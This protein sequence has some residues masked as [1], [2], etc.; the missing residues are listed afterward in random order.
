MKDKGKDLEKFARKMSKEISGRVEERALM[1]RY[2]SFRI[3]G[4][5]E[6]MVFPKN[7]E[8]LALVVE[9]CENQG[10][11][12]K[13]LGRGSN[14]LVSDQG[15]DEVLI[16]LQEGFKG[17][18]SGGKGLVKAEAGVRLA[19]LVKLC[20][21]EGLSG[22]E[23]CAGIP[24]TVGGGLKMN[25][26]AEGSEIK[27]VVTRVE[28]HRYPEGVYSR[29]QKELRFEY[30]SL[31]LR[32]REII[33]GAE[34]ELRESDPREIR[35]RILEYLRSRRQ[36]QPIQWPSAGSVF[37]NPPGKYA[38]KI[39]EELG[40]KGH[41]SGDA[42]ISELHANFIIN[43]GRAKATQV[44]ELIELIREKALREKGIRLETE[45]EVIGRE[46]G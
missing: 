17:V 16:N 38:G 35:A 13:I 44:L 29:R 19:H 3:G 9:M 25:A 41:R 1:K 8:D 12:W 39:I 36:T 42:Q 21:D 11:A 14:L 43:R 26:G 37:K 30:R 2:T 23:F 20:Q 34:F 5:C 15:V 10:L 7:R 28:F 45:I 4:I 22:L 32:E 33:L 24:G 6:L 27:K 46:N 18:E 40:L 31:E